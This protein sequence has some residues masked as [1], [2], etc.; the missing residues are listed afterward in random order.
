RGGRGTFERIVSNIRQVAG[1]CRISIGGN[2]DE[3]SVES[4]PA[5][6]DFLRE[7]EFADKLPRVALRPVMR[8]PKPEQPK[9]MIPL[10]AVSAS[11]KP[12]NGTCMT[13]A[14]GGTSICDKC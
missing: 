3:T 10:T 13:S 11:G 14:G 6:L 9:G 2:F 1:K 4:Y 12:L 7:Q 5:L 8:K